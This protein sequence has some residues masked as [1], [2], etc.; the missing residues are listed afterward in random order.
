MSQRGGVILDDVHTSD[1]RQGL[2]FEM[3]TIE[4]IATVSTINPG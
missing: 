2:Q 3:L 1:T 4:N